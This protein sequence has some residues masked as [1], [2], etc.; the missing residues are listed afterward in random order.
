[1]AISTTFSLETIHEE[2]IANGFEAKP[3]FGSTALG[4]PGGGFAVA[5]GND[6][7]TGDTPHV[8]FFNADG[9][10]VV[11]PLGTFSIPYSGADSDV[12]MIGQPSLS[13]MP[14][15][16]VLVTWLVDDPTWSTNLY[17]AILNPHDGST[18]EAQKL[19]S[20]YD[21]SAFTG[22]G[23]SNGNQVYTFAS[24]PGVY[25]SF[26]NPDGIH[27]A[28]FILGDFAGFPE[29]A[30]VTELKTGELFVT[31]HQTQAGFDSDVGTFYQFWS[32]S[33]GALGNATMLSP[34]DLGNLAV[35]ATR[36]GGSAIVYADS[37]VDGDGL[38][39]T[40]I[41]A[42]SAIDPTP[43]GPIRID[44]DIAAVE[45]EAAVTV[46]DNGFILVTWTHQGATG[47][48]DV[49]ARVFNSNGKAVNIN[50]SADPFVLAGDTASEW[51]SSVSTILG[52]QF[53]TSWTQ[54]GLDVE[55]TGIGAKVQE[56]VRTVIADA[57]DNVINGSGLRDIVHGLDGNDVLAGGRGSDQLYGGDGDDIYYADG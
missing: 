38:M 9:T 52:G 49:M 11:G 54:D 31:Y 1:M 56:L 15:G 42:S 28:T 27:I 2:F 35:A 5:Y 55:G 50:G 22:M 44:T 26:K 32:P 29:N 30:T 48:T 37:S 51:A 18:V 10:P 36:D 3:Q 41:P 6:F 21:I 13:L 53:I 43:V 8:S 19:I 17:S 47:G 46:L 45:S 12:Q 40:I 24:G 14:D 16:N 57:D 34:S 4:L 20:N 39:L 25:L 7:A 23:L 33:G